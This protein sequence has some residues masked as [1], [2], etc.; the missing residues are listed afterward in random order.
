MR[1]QARFDSSALKTR[2]AR[3]TKRL[4]FNTA[5]ALNT[6]AKETQLEERANLDRKFTIRRSAFMYRLIKIFQFANARQGRPFVLLGVD[7]SKKRV[8]L[9]FFQPGAERPAAVGR[10]VAVPLTGGP[11]RPR[12]RDPVAKRFR[13]TA[14]HLRKRKSIAGASSQF[15]GKEGTFVMRGIGVFQRIG[16]QVR[17]VYLFVRRPQLD[18]RLDFFGVARRVFNKAFERNLRAAYTRR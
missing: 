6:T 16:E 5:Q 17:A 12:F 10:S 13:F 15:R 8:L 3:E 11:A 14:L 2:T 1:I 4:A 18:K 9:P 7:R